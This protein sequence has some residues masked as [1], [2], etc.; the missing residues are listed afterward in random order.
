MLSV[1]SE[2]TLGALTGLEGDAL[3]EHITQATRGYLCSGQPDA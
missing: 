1:E 3:V 2:A